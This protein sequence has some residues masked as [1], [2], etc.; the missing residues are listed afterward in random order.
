MRLA[1]ITLVWSLIEGG[2]GVAVAV[3]SGSVALLGFGLD[4]FLEAASAAIILWRN[5]QERRATG[6]AD[7]ERI[8]RQASRLV[9][10]GLVV[11]GVYIVW[12]A[13][14]SLATGREPET[15]RSGIVLAV[16]SMVLM[17]WLGR[18]KRQTA[19]ALG[20][21]AMEA[22]AFQATACFYLSFIALVGMGLNALFG[23][24]W[25]DPVAAL[26]MLLPLAQEA[27]GSWSGGHTH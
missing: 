8:E 11:L 1:I 18:R 17:Q 23:W 20:S 22:D 6:A 9:A 4:A 26:I 10:V 16:I 15:T 13:G 14:H 3:R 27:R 24:W 5:R 2:F 7:V 21:R 25:A 19:R 12:E